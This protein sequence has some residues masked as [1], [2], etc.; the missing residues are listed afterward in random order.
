M[1]DFSGTDQSFLGWLTQYTPALSGR[2]SRPARILVAAFE[3]WSDAGDAATDAVEEIARQTNAELISELNQDEYY[4]YQVTRPVVTRNA[5]GTGQVDWPRTRVFH[6]L[7]GQAHP[8]QPELYFVLGTEPSLRWRQFVKEILDAA[9]Q[10]DIDAVVVTGALL[11]DVPHSRPLTPTKS[12]ASQALRDALEGYLKPTYE[13]PTGI[14]GVLTDASANRGWPTIATWVTVPHYVAQSPS[15]KAQ[16]AMVRELEDLL[17]L[18]L[19]LKTLADD[20]AAWER[21]V[22]ELAA[23]DPDV[24]AY[25]QQ[26]EEAR[27]TEQLPEASGEQ[28]AKEFERYLKRRDEDGGGSATR[29]GGTR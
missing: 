27:D 13:G 17:G 24:A 4:D 11:A 10:W 19:Q 26:L 28:I 15:P 2:T 8:D 18:R 6:A 23:E 9:E 20:A 22:N 16:L 3:G 21:G 7:A 1:S 12:S 14:T 5:D 29:G 25:I